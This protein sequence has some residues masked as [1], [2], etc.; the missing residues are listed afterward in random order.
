M[1]L[2]NSSF[3]SK[4]PNFMALMHRIGFLETGENDGFNKGVGEAVFFFGG[5][6][7]I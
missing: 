2:C 3:S 1:D 4:A 7:L 5:W 6:G